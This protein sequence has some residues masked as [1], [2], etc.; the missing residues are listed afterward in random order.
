MSPRAKQTTAILLAGAALW[1]LTACGSGQPGPTPTPNLAEIEAAALASFE[2][3]WDD[4]TPFSRGLVSSQQ[5]VLEEL[6]GASVYQ[7]A[8]QIADNYR[9][10]EGWLQVRYTNQEAVPLEAIYFR[11]FPNLAGGRS[12]VSAVLVDGEQ[13]P[14]DLESAGSALRLELPSRLAPGEQIVIGMNFIIEVPDDMGGN[15]GLFAFTDKVLSLNAFYPV[16]AAYDRRG[17]KTEV[18]SPNGDVS[19]YDSSFYLVRVTAPAA[20]T[21]AAAGVE[22]DRQQLGDYQIVTYA[23]GPIRDFYL[24]ASERYVRLSREAGEVTINSYAYA[25]AEQGSQFAL[26]VAEAALAVYGRRLGEYPYTE[27][28]MVA[29]PMQALGMEYPG[30]VA[31]LDAQYDPENRV[32]GMPAFDLLES[33]IAH[34]VGHEWFYN[35]VGNDQY[36]EPWLDESLTQFITGLYYL[37]TQ[38]F[39]AY[40]S[41]RDSWIGR[42]KRVEM[43]EIPIGLAAGEYSGL[44]YGAIVYGRGPLFVEALM[45]ELDEETFN[46]FL[47]DY[48]QRYQWGLANREDFEELAEEHCGC[49]LAPLFAAWV[50]R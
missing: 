45:L 25:G 19:Y 33:V 1:L 41:Y 50:D 38:G 29:I 4:R 6:A 7:M 18:P 35:V 10:L 21:L 34:E 20:T 32:G 22:I 39:P 49:D 36:D 28:D 40:R 9:S 43:E 31:M 2:I 12:A 26:D 48:Q 23:A 15:Y 30:I 46:R 5:D 11:L 3:G 14:T 37:D 8:L 44:E 47:R 13:V 24:A 17:W 27:F 42:W 16:I